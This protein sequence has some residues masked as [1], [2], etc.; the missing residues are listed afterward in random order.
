VGVEATIGST[1]VPTRRTSAGVEE[2]TWSP[3]GGSEDH[4][5]GGPNRDAVKGDAGSDVV[6]GGHGRDF[7]VA[8]EVGVDGNDAANGGPGHDVYDAD[9]GDVLLSV[10]TARD[11]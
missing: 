11:C 9:A 10:E 1:E 7:C 2:P 4:V 8:T 3:V 6:Q 5:E